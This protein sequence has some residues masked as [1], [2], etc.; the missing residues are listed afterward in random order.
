VAPSGIPVPL[1]D[2]LESGEVGLIAT[3]DMSSA[4]GM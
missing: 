2:E 4:S 1:T 3:V